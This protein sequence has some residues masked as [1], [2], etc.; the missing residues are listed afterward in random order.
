MVRNK[1]NFLIFVDH[2]KCV[3]DPV[4]CLNGATCQRQWTSARCICAP[5]FQ[6]ERCDTCAPGYYGNS[7]GRYLWAT[8]TFLC[9]VTMVTHVG[10]THGLSYR[11]NIKYII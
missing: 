9:L 5:T 6:G 4:F 11:W 10:R 1:K 3:E 2:D 8:L 7:C